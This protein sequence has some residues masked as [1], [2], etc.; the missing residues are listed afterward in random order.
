MKFDCPHCEQNL[1]ISDEWSG[2][3]FDCPICNQAIAAPARLPETVAT[4]RP[5]APPSPPAMQPPGPDRRVPGVPIPPQGGGGRGLGKFLLGLILLVSAGFSYA[6]VHFDES[7]QQVWKRLIDFVETLAKSAP[8]S[9]PTP[10][11]TPVSTPT[12]PPSPTPISTP[13]PTASPVATPTPIDPIAWLLEHKECAP[14]ELQLLRPSTLS[15]SENGKVIGSVTVPAGTKAQ[16]VGFTSQIVEVRVGYTGGQVS[17]DATNL[18]ALAKKEQ[19]KS[20]PAM[21]SGMPAPTAPI[22]VGATN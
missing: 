18:R 8:A 15:I 5:T 3:E 14:K 13:E 1:E 22:P 2:Y 16:I 19:E 21:E 7:P 9:T 4:I 12:P 20:D 10:A 11:P 17:I 6:M